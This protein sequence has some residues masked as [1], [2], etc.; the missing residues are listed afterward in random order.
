MS[1]ILTAG[2]IIPSS[3]RMPLQETAPTAMRQIKIKDLA[4]DLPEDHHS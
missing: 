2:R 4:S 3:H 1:I